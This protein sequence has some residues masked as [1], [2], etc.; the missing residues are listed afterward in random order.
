MKKKVL[1]HGLLVL[2]ILMSNTLVFAEEEIA[3]YYK[4]TDGIVT[5]N[6]IIYLLVFGLVVL[7][8]TSLIPVSTFDRKPKSKFSDLSK[9]K[10]SVLL[11]GENIEKIKDVAYDVFLKIENAWMNFDYKYLEESC[12]DYLYKEYR[13]QLKNM[14][15]HNEQ[16]IVKDFKLF[17][18]YLIDVEKINEDTVLTI[19]FDVNYDDYIIDTKTKN[20]IKG[21]NRKNRTVYYECKFLYSGTSKTMIKCPKCGAKLDK[22]NKGKCKKCGN[23]IDLINTKLKLSR[24]R[25]VK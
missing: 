9:K 18:Y 15:N 10:L 16:N 4:V 3:G 8:V 19:I 7:L 20:I 5:S 24:K 21:K 25:I 13:S 6:S 2:S 17:D 23:D 22:K 14:Q 11:P 1:L 12:V